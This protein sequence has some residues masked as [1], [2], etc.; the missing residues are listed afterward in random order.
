MT[1]SRPLNDI[2][3]EQ[4]HVMRK[5]L[6][7]A[8]VKPDLII[9]S[10]FKRTN[11][12]ANIMQ[13]GDTPV[14]TTPLLHPDGD[15]SKAWKFIEKQIAKLGKDP[16]DSSPA[17]LIVTHGPLV[18]KLLASVAF[19]FVDEGW[20][21]HHGAIAYVN[22]HESKFRW[23]VNPKLA[24]HLVGE[25]PKE[26]EVPVGEALSVESLTRALE[27]LKAFGD[28]TG[29]QLTLQGALRV[30]VLLSE[31]LMADARKATIE[32]LRNQMRTAV[33]MRWKKQLRRVHKALNRHDATDPITTSAVLA[34]AIPFHDK[35][36]AG[37]HRR[38]KA[39]AYKAGVRHSAAQL[40]V[41]IEGAVQGVEAAAP[42][43][44]KIP[45]PDLESIDDQGYDL[46]D[47]LDKT[48]VDRAHHT[49]MGLDPFTVAG[50]VLAVNALYKGFTDPESGKLS[51]AD[52]VAL[53]TVSN[54]Y[55]AGGKDTVARAADAGLT[56]EKRWD[57]G[58]E[59][60]PQCQE[61]ADEGYIGAD[62]THASGD[63]EP[64]AHPNCDCSEVYRTVKG[65][66][67]E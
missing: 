24:A 58:A 56:V 53:D 16:D 63:D 3:I 39:D 40:G 47:S 38:I 14:I 11:D 51:R 1:A 54:G 46:E 36:F 37:H 48:T 67:E 52:T 62:E 55:H 8:D 17:V 28:E 15:P 35:F 2:G 49:L 42:R 66:E 44:P 9:C 19:C 33:A 50:A 32:P 61:N 23:Y 41:D 64:P 45:A 25:D 13:R 43:R 27:K 6:K 31:N 29:Q 10:D 18:Q 22:T 34:Q 57:I 30:S 5:F 7:L 59:G 12:T 21:F 65:D 4:A 26:V 20:S 60:C